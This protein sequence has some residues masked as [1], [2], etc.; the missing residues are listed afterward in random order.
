MVAARAT[1]A[2]DV[3]APAPLDA[4]TPG[5]AAAAL[6]QSRRGERDDFVLLD[7]REPMEL[8]IVAV[9]GALCMPM[10]EVPR[11]LEELPREAE[12]AVLCHSG[13]RSQAVVNFLLRQGFTRARNVAGGI[14]RWAVQVDPTLR[15]Y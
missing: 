14:D 15:R 10:N 8:A 3:G 5:D 7:V 1:A 6:A 13:Q 4:A 2:C 9:D 11:R 12:I